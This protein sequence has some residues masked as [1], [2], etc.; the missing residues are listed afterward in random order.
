MLNIDPASQDWAR[1]PAYWQT[2]VGSVL[3]IRED[4]KDLNM[5][6]LAMM[7]YFCQHTIQDRLESAMESGPQPNSRQKL[8][9]LEYITWA[10]MEKEY[11]GQLGFSYE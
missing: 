2:R 8:K 3:V 11:K 9:T 7:A 1:A 4:G 5:E 6:D 10:N